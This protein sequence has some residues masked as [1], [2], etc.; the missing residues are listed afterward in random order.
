M[1]EERNQISR[2]EVDKLKFLMELKKKGYN[3]TIEGDEE[4]KVIEK[5]LDN[6]LEF[7]LI[8]MIINHFDKLPKRR[9]E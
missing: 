4:D 9:R 8:E 6:E 5:F 3:I 7:E 1:E 2:R